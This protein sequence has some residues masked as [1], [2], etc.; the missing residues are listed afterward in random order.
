MLKY[1]PPSE[2][3]ENPPEITNPKPDDSKGEEGNGE[4][5]EGGDDNKGDSGETDNNGDNNGDD[6]GGGGSGGSGETEEGGG[7]SGESGEENIENLIYYQDENG[8]TQYNIEKMIEVIFTQYNTKM[9]GQDTMAK[10]IVHVNEITDENTKILVSRFNTETEVTQL[11]LL[12]FATD[13]DGIYRLIKVEQ[14]IDLDAVGGNTIE[15]LNNYFAPLD[16]TIIRPI[17]KTFIRFDSTF[18]PGEDEVADSIVDIIKDYTDSN[19]QKVT[20]PDFEYVLGF[21]TEEYRDVSGDGIYPDGHI[22]SMGKRMRVITYYLINKNGNLYLTEYNTYAGLEE[23]I[24]KDTWQNNLKK[25][26]YYMNEFVEET[27]IFSNYT[28][29]YSRENLPLD[30]ATN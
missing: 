16:F 5:E 11:D 24:T 18:V 28:M 17:Y 1:P 20:N 13:D 27:E 25:H 26:V 4:T 2:P 23:N 9:V 7:G 22:E 10:K 8:E 30:K 29:E 14:K 21:R 3:P 6:K 12:L 15:D 19:G